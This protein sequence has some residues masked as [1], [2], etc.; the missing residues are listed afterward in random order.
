VLDALDG[1]ALRV[2]ATLGPHLG[3]GD[4][5]PPGN[6][7]LAGYLRH[8]AVLPHADLCVNHAG[9]GTIG[10]ALTFGV[11][12]VCLPL[13]RDQP[14]NAEA[15]AAVGAGRVVPPDAPADRIRAT[16]LDVLE[17]DG[18]RRSAARLADEIRALDGPTVAAEAVESLLLL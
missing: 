11:P 15:V 4:L 2:L 12:L 6:A 8:A 9:L 3:T 1:A 13:G 10:A 7:T 5:R 16:V 18:C 14:G 17:D